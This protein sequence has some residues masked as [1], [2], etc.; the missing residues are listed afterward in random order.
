M[1]IGAME[2]GTVLG[3]PAGA[4]TAGVGAGMVAAGSL[5]GLGSVGMA[6]LGGVMSTDAAGVVAEEV[7]DFTADLFGTRGEPPYE[8][9]IGDPHYR[10]GQTDLGLGQ[11]LH[12][13]IFGKD[14]AIEDSMPIR[15]PVSPPTIRP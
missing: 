11:Q 2:S 14:P 8:G 1:A 12:D 10:E 13:A 6:G 15:V 7:G 4:A 9:E 5:L 3:I